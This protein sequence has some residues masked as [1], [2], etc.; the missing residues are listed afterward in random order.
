MK[1]IEAILRHDKLEDLKAHLANA[2]DVGMSVTEVRGFGRQ[3]GHKEIYRDAEYSVDFLPK[4]KLKM[5]V[6][7]DPW[8]T[9]CQIDRQSLPHRRNWQW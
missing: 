9:A 1:M 4:F 6:R 3:R 2:G 8:E 7:N 5:A